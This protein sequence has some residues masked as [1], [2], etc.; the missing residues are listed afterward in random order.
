MVPVP[1]VDIRVDAGICCWFLERVVACVG[2]RVPRAGGMV[3]HPGVYPRWGSRHDRQLVV[4]ARQ[5]ALV[6]AEFGDEE[7]LAACR[8]DL[9]AIAG[10]H[11]VHDLGEDLV[12][13]IGDGPRDWL[14]A[15]ARRPGEAVATVTISACD[16]VRVLSRGQ[17]GPARVVVRIDIDLAV[18]HSVGGRWTSAVSMI[19][20]LCR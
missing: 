9:A 13:L 19:A 2:A 18:D 5:Q 3:R 7:L 11:R 1:E 17:D 14:M 10:D 4:R 8:S 6:D 20:R 16:V 15:N 12:R